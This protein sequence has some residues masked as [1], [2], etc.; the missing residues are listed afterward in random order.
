MCAHRRGDRSP[1]RGR[2]AHLRDA[3]RLKADALGDGRLHGPDAGEA[4]RKD[5]GVRVRK[6][7]GTRALPERPGAGDRHHAAPGAGAALVRS[8]ETVRGGGG[9]VPAAPGH[10]LG[11]K[12]AAL[13]EDAPGDRH[14]RLCR[15]GLREHQGAAEQDLQ[16][17]ACARPQQQPQPRARRHAA[18]VRRPHRQRRRGFGPRGG[19]AGVGRRLRAAGGGRAL[20]PVYIFLSVHSF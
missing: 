14:E 11:A 13:L 5:G 8:R 9:A 2:D 3:R 15:K 16:A 7:R 17:P 1:Q 12:V 19:S 6:I 18:R 4:H 20:P 10:A